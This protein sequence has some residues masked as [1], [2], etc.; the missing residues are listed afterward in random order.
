MPKLKLNM[1]FTFLKFQQNIIVL[2][3][4]F[5][6][7]IYRN[8]IERCIHRE[9]CIV[10]T[11]VKK[12]SWEHAWLIESIN[13]AIV[14]YIQERS[15]VISDECL[16]ILERFLNTSEKRHNREVQTTNIVASVHSFFSPD[17]FLSNKF[18]TMK[19]WLIIW[20][21]HWFRSFVTRMT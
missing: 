12:K 7:Q 5:Y 10:F 19:L 18:K 15:F 21:I 2:K 13:A 9:N 14:S 17:Y 11:D 16:N 20:Q 8:L 6:T 3:I 1:R 4:F